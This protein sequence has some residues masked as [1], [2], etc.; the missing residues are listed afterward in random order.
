MMHLQPEDKDRHRKKQGLFS[1]PRSTFLSF[2]LTH[3]TSHGNTALIIAELQ[4]DNCSMESRPAAAEAVWENPSRLLQP[5]CLPV[6]S[7]CIS[8]WK[9]SNQSEERD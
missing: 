8:V 2:L 4:R 9:Q 5:A 3:S 7:A 6:D 1:A